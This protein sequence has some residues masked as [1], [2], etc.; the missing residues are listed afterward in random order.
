MSPEGV[1]EGFVRSGFVGEKGRRKRKPSQGM[2]DYLSRSVHHALEIHL[3][4]W[5]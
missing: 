1:D 4:W 5:Y 3:D 2:N